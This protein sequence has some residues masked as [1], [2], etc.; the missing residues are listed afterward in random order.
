MRRLLTLALTLLPLSAAEFPV[1]DLSRFEISGSAATTTYKGKSALKL[2]D[3]NSGPGESFAVLKG[4][5]F[6][7]GTIDLELSGAPAKNADPT[8][9]GFIGIAFRVQPAGNRSEII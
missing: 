6:H 1:T 7:N 4:L 2:T 8:A 5:Q 3:K 9:R